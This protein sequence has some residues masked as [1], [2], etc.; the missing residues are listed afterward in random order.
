VARLDKLNKKWLKGKKNFYF[1]YKYKI[2]ESKIIGTCLNVG[3]GEHK[4]KGAR[5]VDYPKVDATKLPYKNESFDTVILSDVIEHLDYFQSQL[6]MAEAYRVAKKKVIITVP[7]LKCLWSKYDE[8]LG[9][10]R[11][12]DKTTNSLLFILNNIKPKYTYLFG[13]LFPLFYI[14]K[15]T[16]GK[17][18]TFPDWVDNILY[19]LSHIRLPFGSTLLMEIEQ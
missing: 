6:A 7:A 2:V 19:W 1:R 13:V 14:R 5:N 16:T 17:T 15:F 10:Y 12:Y 11:R 9:H 8:L 4:I 3:C 18:P